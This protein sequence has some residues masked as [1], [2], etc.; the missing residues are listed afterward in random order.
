MRDN[1]WQGKLWGK[2]CKP[3]HVRNREYQL[4]VFRYIIEHENVGA[5]VWNWR[6]GDPN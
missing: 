2:R 6:G 1:G 5:W 4:N 3:V